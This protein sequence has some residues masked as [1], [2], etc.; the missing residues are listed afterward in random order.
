MAVEGMTAPR[1]FGNWAKVIRI[2]DGD[3]LKV[4]LA[5]GKRATVRM[6]GI[7]TPETDQC[8]FVKAKQ[9]LK[10]YLPR[11]TRVRPR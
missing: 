9:N 6:V 4:R 8:G 1:S 10:D 2:I 5:S 11:G 3:T 7:D